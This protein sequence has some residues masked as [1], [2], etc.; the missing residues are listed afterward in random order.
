MTLDQVY[1]ELYGEIDQ[2]KNELR[3]TLS[4]I[5]YAS[6]FT[7]GVPLGT[8]SVGA[9]SSQV[10]APHVSLLPGAES[11]MMIVDLPVGTES[12]MPVLIQDDPEATELAGDAIPTGKTMESVLNSNF[13]ND[14]GW[15][16]DT[17]TAFGTGKVHYRK[18]Y[19]TINFFLVNQN[20][21]GMTAN[22]S[23]VVYTLPSAYYPH[24]MV[25]AKNYNDNGFIQINT[26]GTVVV[27]PTSTSGWFSVCLTYLTA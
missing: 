19:N 5:Q 22:A 11:G 21:T 14:S 16:E 10:I 3:N 27:N 7:E 23:N 2:I 13:V 24:Q 1:D 17:L 15:I 12:V 18:T 8:I 9:E 6:N 25:V 20:L 4:Q 26:N